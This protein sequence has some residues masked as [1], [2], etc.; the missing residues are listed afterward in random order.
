MAGL[1]I[2]FLVLLPLVVDSVLQIIP[3]ELGKLVNLSG[4][5]AIELLMPHC[6]CML[7]GI[8]TKPL[9]ALPFS[10]QIGIIEAIHYCISLE[11]P[12]VELNDELLR[13]L[14]E[15]LALADADNV[16]LLVLNRKDGQ[17]R[18]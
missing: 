12:L 7:V 6:N 14:H 10:K 1:R 3:K 4:R 13:L 2:G 17:T 5:P 8:F 11:P 9:R 18:D 15:T 16:Q